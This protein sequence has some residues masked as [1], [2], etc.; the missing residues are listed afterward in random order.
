MQRLS[1][2]LNLNI[3]TLVSLVG[4]LVAG[5]TSF[6]K[7]DA[8][9]AAGEVY[10]Q[11]RSEQTD[12]NFADIRTQ[13]EPLGNVPYRV[14]VVEQQLGAVNDRVDRLV[15][16]LTSSIDGLRDD[17]S[18]LTTRVEVLVTR[19]EAITPERRAS[20]VEPMDR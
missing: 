2:N 10:R 6:N 9:I 14:T 5:V 16:A 11:A 4:L 8:R 17:V 7:L 13:L 20:L 12:G 15:G 1:W 19:I 3:P 18:Q